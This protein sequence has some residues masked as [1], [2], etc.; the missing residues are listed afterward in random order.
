MFFASTE[1]DMPASPLRP[2]DPTDRQCFTTAV[3][4]IGRNEGERL[5]AC[6]ASLS[7][8][9]LLVVY[10]DSGSSDGSPQRAKPYCAEVVALNPSRPFSA[11]RA[12]NEGFLAVMTRQPETQ[13]VQ[14][15]V[16]DCT[17]LPGWISSAAQAMEADPQRAVVIGP[18]QERNP[19]ASI[20]NRLCSL[21]WKSLPGDL[22]NFGNLGGI[23]LVRASVF[24]ELK[25]FNENVIAGEDS[26]FGVRVGAAGSKITKIATAMATH[27]ADIHRFGQWW[28][29]AV[30]S[31][32]AIGQRF[33]LNGLSAARDCAKE[34]RSVVVWGLALPAAVLLLALPTRGLSLLLCLGYWVLAQRVTKY[35]LAQGDSPAD[36]RLYARFNTLGKIAEGLGLL[37]FQINKLFGRYKIIEYK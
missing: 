15:I 36:A 5:M 31:G 32:H 10:V 11:A 27:D 29:R 7:S 22:Q 35:R 18:L 26:E 33:N 1:R 28:T 14:F 24:A 17:L 6:L 37:K 34:R 12:R 3:V 20:Y 30:R 16:G 4:V 21:E 8:L 19:N 25:G 23:M 9:G 2:A 13:L